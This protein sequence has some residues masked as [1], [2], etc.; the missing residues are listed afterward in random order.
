[1]KNV[2]CSIGF[3]LSL[4]YGKD[5]REVAS[6]Y[7][8]LIKPLV[9]LIYHTP[10]IPVSIY[11]GGALLEMLRSHNGAFFDVMKELCE[12]KQ[13]EILGGGFYEPLFPLISKPDRIGQVELLTTYLRQEFGKRPR[14]CYLPFGI[15]S[16]DLASTLATAGMEYVLLPDVHLSHAGIRMGT[17][18][19]FQ[20]Y[21]T[22]H[23]GKTLCLLP[24]STRLKSTLY[25]GSPR[26]FLEGLLDLPLRD[27]G[28]LVLMEDFA[29]W[30]T[31]SP[32]RQEAVLAWWTEL[33]SLLKT[34][35]GELDLRLP[36]DVVREIVPT[37]RIHLPPL[38]LS[39]EGNSEHFYVRQEVSRIEEPHLLYAKMQYVQ[40]LVRQL[41]GDRSRKKTA[42]EDL[43]RGQ[44]GA[45]YSIVSGDGGVAC[46][47]LRHAAYR[48]LIQAEKNTREKGIFYPS[49]VKTDFTFDGYPE[50]LFQGERYNAYLST[51]GGAVF[52]LDILEEEW[53]LL[54]TCGRY[55]FLKLE[56]SSLSG[57]DK[58]PRLLFVDRFYEEGVTLEHCIRGTALVV[59]DFSGAHYTV[60]HYSRDVLD[61][62][63]S[64]EGVVRQ[65]RR[66]TGI[67]ISKRYLFGPDTLRVRYHLV[68]EGQPSHPLRFVP[69]INLSFPPQ[70]PRKMRYMK[71]GAGG[72]RDASF[73]EAGKERAEKV[74]FLP[75]GKNGSTCLVSFDKEVPL[76]HYPVLTAG[77][78]AGETALQGIALLPLVDIFP[79]TS[80]YT[81]EIAISP[82]VKG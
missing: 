29:S 14:G 53:N 58:E 37:R 54:A 33:F 70:V 52:E 81:L 76:W 63:L 80:E 15:W 9:S 1:M 60:D 82:A 11:M 22:E 47:W 67:H 13:V 79:H 24:V 56:G 38:I 36:R 75:E 72:P 62:T 46:P 65:G 66:Q 42:R 77:K 48:A 49:V 3:V 57:E 30:S 34:R 45:A 25:Q 78:K 17:Q 10:Q 32:S 12:R 64:H 73:L 51:K 50:Y 20:H 44:T 55:P 21:I 41:R 69:E 19:A 35:Y 59:A 18:A 4:P 28:V 6:F 5:S 43:Y 61:I 71:E 2:Q 7:K 27:Q 16:P 68:L 40:S 31:L 39:P 23:D 74:L 26:E 8:S